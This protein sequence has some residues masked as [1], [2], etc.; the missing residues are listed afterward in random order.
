MSLINGGYMKLYKTWLMFILG[1]AIYGAERDEDIVNMFL[2]RPLSPISIFQKAYQHYIEISNDR[3][4]DT[5]RTTFETF[6]HDFYT[7]RLN[8]R[9]VYY[10][11]FQDKTPT[12]RDNFI[13]FLLRSKITENELRYD[14]EQDTASYERRLGIMRSS[15]EIRLELL[16]RELLRR[17]SS[18]V[19]SPNDQSAQ[20][21]QITQER[22]EYKK[23]LQNLEKLPTT[24]KEYNTLTAKHAAQVF[25][26][27][28]FKMPGG[29][30]F[31]T[32]QDN[33]AK[34]RS[35][36]VCL[37]Q[38]STNFTLMPNCSHFFCSPCYQGLNQDEKIK[39]PICRNI[40]LFL[41]PRYSDTISSSQAAVLFE[42]Q[43]KHQRAHSI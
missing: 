16:R 20:L 21:L 41:Q 17:N 7:Q 15:H 12:T 5:L 14:N 38:I 33:I 13:Y 40:N 27:A 11:L 25:S 26:K 24:Q 4:I 19:P 28:F 2:N 22:D 43:H 39:C 32:L 6:P 29:S 10:N 3:P 35:C 1:N 8:L 37:E 23:I 36:G 30:T 34:E 9:T 18:R 42:K 31:E